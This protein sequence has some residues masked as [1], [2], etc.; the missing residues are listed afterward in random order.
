M[1]EKPESCYRT[2]FGYCNRGP[3]G[4][5]EDGTDKLPSYLPAGK[6]STRQAPKSQI[7]L[8]VA[9]HRAGG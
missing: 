9:T 5:Y 8:H 6:K 1:A 7:L 4:L 2:G 3:D